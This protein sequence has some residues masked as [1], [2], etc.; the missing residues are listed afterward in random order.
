MHP[1]YLCS[2]HWAYRWHNI[3]LVPWGNNCNSGYLVVHCHV[4]ASLTLT[5]QMYH[6]GDCCFHIPPH[7]HQWIDLLEHSWKANIR[8][9][10]S[11]SENN[12]VHWSRKYWVI[13]FGGGGR[14]AWRGSVSQTEPCVL[15]RTHKSPE[16][17]LLAWSLHR[18]SHYVELLFGTCILQTGSL[19]SQSMLVLMYSH[20]CT[21]THTEVDW[22]KSL[23]ITLSLFDQY[24]IQSDLGYLLKF[25]AFPGNL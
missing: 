16:V 13:F 22:L 19:G 18:K 11:T 2:E 23:K 14:G 1:L 21:C 24:K 8:R 3:A 10:Q 6:L 17:F 4:V 20:D 12:S 5:F 15:K 25:F 9:G 7:S